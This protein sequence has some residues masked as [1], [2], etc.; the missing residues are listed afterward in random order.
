[1]LKQSTAFKKLTWQFVA[2][3]EIAIRTRQYDIVDIMTRTI[4]STTCGDCVLK[5]EDILSILLLKLGKATCSIVATVVLCLQ[6]SLNLGRS[7]RARN[8]SV[9][10]SAFMQFCTP[11]YS[12]LLCLAI[13]P[14][15]LKRFFSMI[16]VILSKIVPLMFYVSQK[17]RFMLLAHLFF[18]GLIIKFSLLAYLFFSCLFPG[19]CACICACL[20]NNAKSI[21]LT[22]IFGKRRYGEKLLTCFTLLQRVVLGYDV[23][24]GTS[25]S[26]SVSSRQDDP[27]KQC[28]AC[29][30][31]F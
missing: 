24:H 17:I 12:T 30:K 8:R 11:Y 16:E 27:L 5:M 15:T 18:V 7:K 4:L 3:L 13:L 23:T 28:K 14:R 6:F 26:S 29:E 21:L 22:L 9:S 19:S 20:A 10:Q 2:L 1:M 25:P 31:F